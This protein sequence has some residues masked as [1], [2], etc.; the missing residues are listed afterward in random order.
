MWRIRVVANHMPSLP[1]NLSNPLDDYFDH[2][3]AAD[4]EIT[5]QEV[6]WDDLLRSAV[7]P[8]H[9]QEALASSTLK[10][11]YAPV[12]VRPLGQGGKAAQRTQL[13]FAI[14][15]IRHLPESSLRRCLLAACLPLAAETVLNG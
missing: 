15:M 13:L 1:T 5:D 12:L 3:L 11:G 6:N 14:G 4:G 8:H 10:Q 7:S 9:L 2:L